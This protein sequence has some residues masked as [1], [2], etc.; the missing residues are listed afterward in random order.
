MLTIRRKISMSKVITKNRDVVAK[1]NRLVFVDEVLMD[2]CQE[3]FPD[4]E[5]GGTY[6]QAGRAHARIY[7]H[8][9][10]LKRSLL[11]FLAAEV[12]HGWVSAKGLQ[13]LKDGWDP[14]TLK[15]YE[16]AEK[17]IVAAI[18]KDIKEFGK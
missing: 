6:L 15:Q 12:K 16:R 18:E 7:N 9:R 14:K 4:W 11:E 5:E 13:R 8:A 3:I 2:F 1:D 10:N 17:K